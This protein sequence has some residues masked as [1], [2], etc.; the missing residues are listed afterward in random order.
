MEVKMARIPADLLPRIHESWGQKNTY[1]ID[2]FNGREQKW[3]RAQHELFRRMN[4]ISACDNPRQLTPYNSR[5]YFNQR[6]LSGCGGMVLPLSFAQRLHMDDKLEDVLN[7]NGH[8]YST[9]DLILSTISSVIAGAPR[10]YDVNVTRHDP[11]I[12]RVLGLE[13]LPEEG[14]FRKQLAKVTGQEAEAL[15]R[16][17]RE[18][19]AQ[20]NQT[21][22]M[23][24]IGIDFDLTTAT[25]YTENKGQKGY[26]PH[27]KGR[28]CCQIRVAFLSNNGDCAAMQLA[29]GNTTSVTDFERF[30]QYVREQL[31]SNYRIVFSRLDKGYFS[32]EVFN[33]FENNHIY[34]VAAAKEYQDL[35]QIARQ[36]DTYQKVKPLKTEKLE[37]EKK[38]DKIFWTAEIDYKC[39]TWK[40]YRRFIIVKEQTLNPDY[41]PTDVDL[42]GKPK[43]PEY[44]EE[45]HFYVTNIPY[46]KMDAVSLWRFYNERAT[47]ENRIKESKLGFYLDKLPS[48]NWGGNAF[49]VKLVAL[50][51]NLMNWFKRFVLPIEF[52]SKSIRWLRFYLI[53]IPALIERRKYQWFIKFSLHY[54]F[55]DLFQYAFRQLARGKPR[56]K[57]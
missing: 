11:G 24:E 45:Y 44:L 39:D 49:Y 14:N 35:F 10:L 17:H 18:C 3:V 28:P 46:D 51:Y 4:P 8:F 33:L 22:E 19:L 21:E 47:V 53:L 12:T 41:D 30:F 57:V 1:Y 9:S 25:V 27:K 31:P 40:K 7:H 56:Y 50:T 20:C 6:N 23:V 52:R 15:Q 16:V 36:L 29:A 54:P 42:F 26:N 55:P 48:H 13:S 38:E 34:Y 43:Q 32:D 2:P 37:T 5:I